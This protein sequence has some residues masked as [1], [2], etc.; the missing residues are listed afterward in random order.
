VDLLEELKSLLLAFDDAG[1]EY[2][3]CGGLAMAVYGVPRA[4]MDIDVL[5]LTSDVAR[6]VDAAKKQGFVLP[7]GL[8]EF[9]G[10]KIRIHRVSKPG[11]PNEESIPLD[12]IEVRENLREIWDSRRKVAW[13]AG[14]L[15]V[16]GK[17]GLASLKRLRN[18]LQDQADLSAL[19]RS[20]HDG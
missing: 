18:S 6:A 12:M 2:A 14:T 11:G 4:T 3:L 9:S 20:P 15:V 17:G 13:D 7:A 5:V 8:M 1:V 10:G 16:V 19:E